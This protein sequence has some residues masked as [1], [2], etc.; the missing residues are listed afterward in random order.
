MLAVLPLDRDNNMA[1]F[2]D[3]AIAEVLMHVYKTSFR[4]LR[5]R[6]DAH[7]LWTA[8][9]NRNAVPE[10][11]VENARDPRWGEMLVVA[12]RTTVLHVRALQQ[13]LTAC[14]AACLPSL[15]SYY[16]DDR[17]TLLPSLASFSFI[18]HHAE[19]R[20]RAGHR[21]GHQGKAS[22]PRR[23]DPTRNERRLTRASLGSQI[24][25]EQAELVMSKANAARKEEQRRR[26]AKRAARSDAAAAAGS[27]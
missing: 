3:D 22:S 4:R 17:L 27:S 23:R 20:A 15:R 5:E 19:H 8:F 18:D 25:H 1:H 10:Q 26:L 21:A 7:E 2:F 11:P 6:Q 24:K 9:L 14:Q 12:R 16:H 13:R